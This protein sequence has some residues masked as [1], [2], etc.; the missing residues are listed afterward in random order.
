M[1]M[2]K[3]RVLPLSIGMAGSNGRKMRVGCIEIYP[4]YKGLEGLEI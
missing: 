2:I 4:F 1:A 3:S